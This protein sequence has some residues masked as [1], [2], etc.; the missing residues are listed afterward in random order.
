M[1]CSVCDREVGGAILLDDG[2]RAGGF[3]ADGFHRVGIER[4]GIRALT[5]RRGK[6]VLGG[7]RCWVLPDALDH[8]DRRSP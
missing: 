2:H 8:G 4:D 1:V 7:S 3:C 5:S 6:A